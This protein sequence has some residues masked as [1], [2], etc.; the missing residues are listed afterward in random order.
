MSLPVMTCY[1]VG[2]MARRP[3][4]NPAPLHAQIRQTLRDRILDGSYREHDQLPS[5]SELM[6]EFDVSRITV[7]RALGDLESEHV[8]FRLPGKGSFV[9]KATPV[10][11]LARLEGFA[12]A[13]SAQGFEIVN[14]VLSVKRLAATADVS[15][16]LQLPPG[17]PVSEIRRVRL[18]NRAPVSLDVTY[19]AA[20]IGDRLARE[21][22]ATRDIFLILENDYG[23]TLGHADLQL[24]ATAADAELARCLRLERGAPILHVERLTHTAAGMPLDFEHLYYRGDGFKHRLRIDRSRS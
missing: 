19:V 11:S 22:L 2:P 10:Q 17:A 5:E 12:E 6:H 15:E 4:P 9:S 7:R 23:I 3:P 13:M 21:D 20:A 24:D 1:S 8:I 16:R 18:L 14:R